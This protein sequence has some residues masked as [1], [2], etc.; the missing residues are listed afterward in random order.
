M[1]GAITIFV[2]SDNI[3]IKQETL[4]I[5]IEERSTPTV[6]E[7]D[8]CSNDAKGITKRNVPTREFSKCDSCRKSRTKVLLPNHLI[9]ITSGKKDGKTCDFCGDIMEFSNSCTMQA[10][11]GMVHLGLSSIGSISHYLLNEK[12]ALPQSCICI[13]TRDVQRKVK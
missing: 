4:E 5:T 2:D 8:Y 12:F 6:P 9:N 10:I 3:E 1:S 13:V 7:H 11:R